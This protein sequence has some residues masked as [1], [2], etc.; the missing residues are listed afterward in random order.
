[1]IALWG[2]TVLLVGLVWALIL[3]LMVPVM[4]RRRCRAGEAFIVVGSLIATYPG[5]IVLYCVFLVVLALASA[6]IGCVVTCATCCIAALPYIGT[7]ILLPVFVTLR[8]FLLYFLRQFGP[9][10]DVWAGILQPESPPIPPSTP[11]P[12]PT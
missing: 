3:H 9:D 6:I 10:Y 12:L 7:V 8:S 1:M 4:Y 5:E 2:S 11:P